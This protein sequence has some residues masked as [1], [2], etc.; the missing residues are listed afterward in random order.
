MK[1]MFAFFKFIFETVF[2]FLIP[3][4]FEISNKDISY[5]MKWVLFVIFT[6]IYLVIKCICIDKPKVKNEKDE[7]MLRFVRAAFSG[8]HEI[9]ESKRNTL[10]RETEKK[11]IDI[12]KNILPY[13]VHKYIY[14]ICNEFKK[15]IATITQIDAGEI[16]C[17]FIYRYVYDGCNSKDREWKW[18]AGKE[19]TN[20]SKINEFVKKRTTTYD[21]IINGGCHYIF[22]DSKE[23]LSKSKKY[24]LSSNDQMHDN[25][26]SVFSIL[27][28]F[29][30]NS[31]DFVEGI[32]TITTHGCCFSDN[33]K[34]DQAAEFLER[35]ILDN[36]FPYYQKLIETELGLMYIRHKSRRCKKSK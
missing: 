13:D 12:K 10:I 34:I 1:K 15:V 32:L 18:I 22:G 14:D 33:L 20:R 29:G 17:V 24:Y 5:R 28:A 31:S 9:I 25:V 23:K 2:P 19:P 21:N 8:T 26:G 35:V 11:Y 36:I 7:Y 4:I 16:S 30:N 3:F 6:I 27:V